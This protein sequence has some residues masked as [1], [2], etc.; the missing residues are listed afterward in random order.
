MRKKKRSFFCR[1]MH[2]LRDPCLE[3]SQNIYSK[4][5]LHDTILKLVPPLFEYY[6]TDEGQRLDSGSFLSF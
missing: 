4:C 6:L 5:L 1:H 3:A 2:T